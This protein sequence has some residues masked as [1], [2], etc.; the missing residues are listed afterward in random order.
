[1]AVVHLADLF[2]DIQ[3]AVVVVLGAAISVGW[4]VSGRLD[5]AAA[6]GLLS[7]ATTNTPSLAAAQQALK[8]V[9][10]DD[11]AA[12]VQG[13]AY[14]VAYPFG[15]IGIILTMLVVKAVFRVD[16]RAEVAAAEAALA[17][18]REVPPALLRAAH[19]DLACFPLR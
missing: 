15:I 6:V 3:P 9:G 1:M 7:G 10:A 17:G 12:V 14:A 4:I 2:M 8:Q 18:A 16:V 13:L 5:V 19:D 11:G